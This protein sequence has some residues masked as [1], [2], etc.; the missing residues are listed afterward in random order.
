MCFMIM[1]AALTSSGALPSEATCQG[2]SLDGSMLTIAVNPVT[3]QCTA[4]FIN[5]IV[6]VVLT[7]DVETIGDSAFENATKL[8]SVEFASGFDVI[9]PRA[10]YGTP[11]LTTLVLP[12]SFSAVEAH[13]FVGSGLRQITFEQVTR[14]EPLAFEGALHLESISLVSTQ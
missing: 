6:H 8:Q 11:S 3:R 12:D 9:Q 14:I 10:F 5:T 2:Y 13:A 4:E 7:D 1:L